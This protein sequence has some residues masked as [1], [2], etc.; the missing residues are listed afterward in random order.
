MT[1]ANRFLHVAGA[2]LLATALILGTAGL[3]SAQAQTAELGKPAPTFELK[4]VNGKAVKLADFRGKTVVLEWFNPGCPFVKYAHGEGPLKDPA[5]RPGA[6]RA[7]VVWLAI[8]SSAAGKQGNGVE[9]NKTATAEW[10][11]TYPLLIDE[12][13]DVGRLYGAKTT[14]HMYVIDATGKLVYRGALDNAPLGRPA[15]KETVNYVQ[16]A[17]ADLAAKKPVRTA[18]TQA[19]G[20]SVKY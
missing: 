3:A 11:M 16:A 19:Y 2:A 6:D 8:N 9:L 7:D 18:E 4:D 10:K 20:C 12:K 15:D 1:N 13:G 17:L 5:K 14:P